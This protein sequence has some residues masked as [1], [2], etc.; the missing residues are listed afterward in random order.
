MAK[1]KDTIV[2]LPAYNEGKNIK[3]VIKDIRDNTN[4]VDIV[5]V[6]D[7]S[8]DNTS[9]ASKETGVQVIDLP[10]NLGIGGAVQT[11]FQYAL[12]NNYSYAMQFDGDGQHKGCEI[13]KLLDKIKK[14]DADVVI[15][16]RFLKGGVSAFRSTFLRRIGIFFLSKL[17]SVVTRQRLTDPTSGFRV[18]N[19]DAII[20]LAKHYPEDYPEPEAI[21][22]LKRWGFRI[23]EIPTV[24]QERVGSF[25]SITTIKSVY[26]MV[27]VTLAILVD[28]LR[29]F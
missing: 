8:T 18:A 21:V 28:L 29:K 10:V 16:S 7:G 27:K 20:R 4:E 26:Y 24:M 17:I 13:P 5:V 25:S 2:I 11:G 19:R 12:D 22:L 3:N 9:S 6:N 23:T 15:G 14:G 1:R